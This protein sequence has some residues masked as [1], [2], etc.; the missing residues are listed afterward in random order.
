MDA[1]LLNS[2]L[3]VSYPSERTKLHKSY[4]YLVIFFHLCLCLN[5]MLTGLY[6]MAGDYHGKQSNVP[7][8]NFMTL[9]QDNLTRVDG[10]EFGLTFQD[11]GIQ[12]GV[13]S[14][15]EALEHTGTESH[16][17]SFRLPVSS[18]KPTSIMGIPKP[19]NVIT[20]HFFTEACGIKQQIVASPLG[21]AQWQV[22]TC[23][24]HLFSGF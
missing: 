18:T 17:A 3:P 1:G 22:R 23:H 11:P 2:H 24:N 15:V 14:W 13:A 4:G 21:Q 8:F 7:G 16:T 9:G 12:N 6:Y 5:G 10:S 20:G 19:E